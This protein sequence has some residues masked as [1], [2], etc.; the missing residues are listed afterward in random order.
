MPSA[1]SNELMNRKK[2]LNLSVPEELLH[3]FDTVCKQYGHAKQKG[4]VLSAALLMFLR[5]DPAEQGECLKQIATA[6]ITHGIE[7]LVEQIQQEQA[8]T[9]IRR[10]GN[11][12]AT[13]KHKA[14]KR[15]SKSVHRRTKLPDID[16]LKKQAR[17]S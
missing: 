7:A 15:A 9:V 2:T 1:R 5:S 6:Q 8:D 13:T 3:Q 11:Q 17:K 14:A 4:M 16:D 10:I 12:T